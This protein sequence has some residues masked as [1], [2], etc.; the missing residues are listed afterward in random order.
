MV[1]R[2]TLADLESTSP[3]SR[4]VQSLGEPIFGH[5]SPS[6]HWNGLK[7]GR[8]ISIRGLPSLELGLGGR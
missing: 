3:G 1:V 4:L 2:A 6:H 5:S 8:S 7:I